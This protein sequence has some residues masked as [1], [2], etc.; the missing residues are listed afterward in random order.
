MLLFSSPSPLPTPKAL[1]VEALLMYSCLSLP[2]FFL[3][4]YQTNLTSPLFA[5]GTST[6]GKET[7]KYCKIIGLVL[8]LD[9]SAVLTGELVDLG[10]DGNGDDDYNYRQTFVLPKL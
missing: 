4:P 6:L 1:L 5:V 9:R 10:D 8:L 3:K 2:H 7:R